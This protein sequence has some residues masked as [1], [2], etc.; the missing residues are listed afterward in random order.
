MRELSGSSRSSHTYSYAGFKSLVDL[1]SGIVRWFLEPASRM[2]D[3]V[4]SETNTPPKQIP[5]GIQDNVVLDWSKEFVQRLSSREADSKEEVGGELTWNTETSLHAYGH[6]TE[7]YD[8][9]RNL[10]EALG[11]IFRQKLLDESA[12]EQRVFSIVLRD[13]ASRELSEVLDLGIRLGY[14]HKSDNAS[15]E[16]LGS[17][18]P[19]YI[20]ARRLGP[21]YRLDVSGY[22]AHLSVTAADLEIALKDPAEFVKIRLRQGGL[23]DRQ[24]ALDLERDADDPEAF[25]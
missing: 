25:N 20:L 4:V 1:S 2:Y 11:R 14:L 21:Y 6:E 13:K 16:A 10:V 24:Y 22:S 3:L 17:R 8:R 19:R 18:L 5:V 12:S 9:L 23:D 7:L 15:K